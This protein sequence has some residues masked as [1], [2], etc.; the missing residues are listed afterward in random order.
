MNLIISLIY[1]PIVLFSL[2]YFDI[3]VASVYIFIFSSMWFLINVKKGFKEYGFSI[4]YMLFALF[5]YFTESSLFLKITP[6]IL[7]FIV[8]SFIFYSYI[9]KSSFVIYYISKF[10][11][12]L[13]DEEKI[14]LQNSTL[15]WFFVALVNLA[16]HIYI[17]IYC[18]ILIWMGYSSFGWYFIFILAGMLQYLHRKLIFKRVEYV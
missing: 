11:K 17:I 10:K 13:S 8:T 16:L 1:A 15:F 5:A 3:K 2:K 14:Y 6:S 7:A 12:N 4:L 9:T 18:D